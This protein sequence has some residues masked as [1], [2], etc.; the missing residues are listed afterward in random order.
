[1]GSC[2]CARRRKVLRGV[3]LKLFSRDL[4][5]IVISYFSNAT[6]PCG[7]SP[8][9]SGGILQCLFRGRNKSDNV[10]GWVMFF[11]HGELAQL[12]RDILM[13]SASKAF[14]E[15]PANFGISCLNEKVI[16]DDLNLLTKKENP[17][18]YD[19]TQH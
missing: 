3:L 4:A 8:R 15:W 12:P 14:G 10:T 16:F 7:P 13:N 2:L 19:R 1:M 17:Y 11:W 9:C 5:F 6:G 18:E